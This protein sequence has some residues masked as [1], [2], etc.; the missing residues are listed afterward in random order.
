MRCPQK[1]RY[2]AVT[3]MAAAGLPV[4]LATRVLGASESG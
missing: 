4:Q 3:V 2:E 1:R